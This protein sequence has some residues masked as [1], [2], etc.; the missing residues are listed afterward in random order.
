MA[1]TSP[2]ARRKLK[3]PIIA[4]NEVMQHDRERRQKEIV[5]ITTAATTE[6]AHVAHAS[7]S[8]VT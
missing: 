6:L 7:R 1:A 4:D 5:S 3:D 2:M 8:L